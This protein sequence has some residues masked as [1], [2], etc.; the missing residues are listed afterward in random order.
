MPPPPPPK[1]GKPGYEAYI[2]RMAAEEQK[3]HE[4]QARKQEEWNQTSNEFKVVKHGFAAKE[5][6]PSD[7]VLHWLQWNDNN[8]KSYPKWATELQSVCPC[9]YKELARRMYLS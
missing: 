3:Y 9:N 8:L 5:P 4:E 1:K 6:H 2:N 7:D